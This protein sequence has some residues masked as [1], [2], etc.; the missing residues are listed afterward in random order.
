MRLP[1]DALHSGFDCG[2]KQ[3][4]K[5]IAHRQL[6]RFLR[7]RGCALELV[8]I[9]GLTVDGALDGF[10]QDDREELPVGEPLNPDVEEQPAIALAGRMLALE[11]EGQGG[12]GE[13]DRQECDE[14]GQ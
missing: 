1:F 5:L 4:W 13:V 9:E 7:H 14:E 3:D 10:E 12:G 2:R 11:R 8:P 6:L